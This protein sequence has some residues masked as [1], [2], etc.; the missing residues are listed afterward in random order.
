MK[1]K[2][3]NVFK[4]IESHYY[5]LGIRNFSFADDTLLC[6][7][8]IKILL[9]LL[10]KSSMRCKFFTPNGIHAKFITEEVAELMFETGFSGL[11]LGLESM[12]DEFHEK[13]DGKVTSRDFQ[14]GVKA[15]KKAGYKG[16]EIGAYVMVGLPGQTYEEGKRSLDFVLDMGIK[17]Y[18]TQYT[19]IPHSTLFDE[20]CKISVYDIASDPIYHNNSILPLSWEKFGFKELFKLKEYIKKF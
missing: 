12:D 4:E 16:K 14:K 19:P 9:G 1:R 17:P 2:P 7:D 8:E 3:E 10:V 13:F 15:L 18:L 20:A 6:G 5:N 11:K